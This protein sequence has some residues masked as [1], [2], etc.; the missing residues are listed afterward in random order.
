METYIC[1]DAYFKEETQ[2]K[3]LAERILEILLPLSD[4]SR[5]DFT[6][7]LKNSVG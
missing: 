6:P 3:Y 2:Y 7:N 5:D 4:D 1:V